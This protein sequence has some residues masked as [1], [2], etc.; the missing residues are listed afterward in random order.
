MRGGQDL[1]DPLLH[2]PGHG[3]VGDPAPVEIPNLLLLE[4]ARHCA[5]HLARPVLD[6]AEVVGAEEPRVVVDG[7]IDELVQARVGGAVR[8]QRPVQRRP[9]VRVAEEEP[10]CVPGSGVLPLPLPSCHLQ[11]IGERA[12]EVL[13]FPEL[14]AELV[15]PERAEL[16]CQP[17]CE[18]GF[19]GRLGP[20]EDDALDQRRVDERIKPAAV[21]V[22]VGTDYRARGRHERP[23]LVD[24]DVL[25]AE[26][27][28]KA[29]VASLAR[30]H[31]VES[32]QERDAFRIDLRVR[33]IVGVEVLGE[34]IV[35]REDVLDVRVE[36]AE[37]AE[38]ELD[39]HPLSVGPAAV[40]DDDR[41]VVHL[42]ERRLDHQ[43]VTAMER[44]ELPEDEA[45]LHAATPACR[46]G[47]PT[48]RPSRSIISPP[49]WFAARAA[50]GS[51][52]G[53][54]A[55]RSGTP[56]VMKTPSA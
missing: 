11:M 54:Q 50:S 32:T 44:Q 34:R 15:R 24:E 6:P 36:L 47:L 2:R 25:G 52:R 43:L 10:A 23:R 16:L 33:G 39:R 5:H 14:P 17:L 21:G 53:A 49:C 28:R 7:A 19:P 51:R 26:E 22:G 4:L 56:P 20:D 48:W 3:H 8:A 12:L 37:P 40:V 29:L 13:R 30:E 9:G 46:S 45:A 41:Q 38:P 1:L 31:L 35:E 42:R 27:P 55:A 18:R